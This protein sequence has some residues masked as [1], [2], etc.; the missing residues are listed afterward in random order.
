MKKGLVVNG[1]NLNML[2]TREPEIYGNESLLDV[3]K[4]VNLILR[5]K[6]S[7]KFINVF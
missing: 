1:P 7:K 5:A 6:S 4:Y 2:G 3:E